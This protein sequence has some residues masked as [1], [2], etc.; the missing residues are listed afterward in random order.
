M[1]PDSAVHLDDL[2]TA[3]NPSSETIAWLRDSFRRHL[4]GDSLP[5]AFGPGLRDAYH[6]H[7]WRQHIDA[8]ISLLDQPSVSNLSIAKI[9]SAEFDRQ[10]R[11]CRKPTEPLARH[12][13]SA[14][15]A[16]PSAAST[17]DALW[18]EVR[19]CRNSK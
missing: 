10:R 18:H 8:A 17:A 9:L 4:D 12:V 5:V 3:D 1:P 14:L 13:R 7:H 15:S 19:R 11:T 16:Y 2:L 6:R